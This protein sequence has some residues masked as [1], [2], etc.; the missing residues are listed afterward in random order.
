MQIL[1]AETA[2]SGGKA[3]MTADAQYTVPRRIIG[4]FSNGAASAVAIK[5]SEQAVPVH[6]ATGAEHPDND[7]F[8]HDCQ[9]WFGREIK[10]IGSDEFKNTW[11]VWE[12]RRYIA[13]ID[14]APCTTE[15]KV[16][17]RL[18]FQRP[19][20]IHVFG[21]TADASDVT[22]ALRMANNYPELSIVTPL[23]F[24]GLTKA[25]CIA[26]L[27][28]AGIKPPLTYAMGFTNANCLP[29]GKATSPDYWALVRKEFPA[30]FSRM[31]KLSRKLGA[32]LCRIEGERRFIDEI[33]DDW[34]ITNP[35][36]P[37]C[38]FLCHIA[39]QEIA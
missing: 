20:D 13:G 37:S 6:C 14:G 4:W 39:E 3:T 26:M 11:A 31:A 36:T 8:R 33:P 7:R 16:G 9:E 25:A 27:E 34:P 32:R 2:V 18:S 15:L 10:S 30:K 24:K 21:Y 28:R 1:R 19:D 29:C 23:I 17:P 35:I 38:D 12:K 22:R 5:L